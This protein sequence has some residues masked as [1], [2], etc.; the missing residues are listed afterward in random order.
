MAITPTVI[1]KNGSIVLI[2]TPTSQVDLPHKLMK[3]KAYVSR[4][5]PA[6]MIYPNTNKTL[7]ELRHP[8]MSLNDIKRGMDNRIAFTREYLCKPLS[9]GDELFPYE[10]IQKA[11]DYQD[12][13]I[14]KPRPGCKYFIG[15]D[16]AL[17]GKAGADYSAYVVY[18]KNRDGVLKIVRIE[19]YKGLSSLAQKQRIKE[20]NS[21]F[22]PVLMLGDEGTF[23]KALIEDL[24]AEHLPIKGFNFQGKRIELLE[25]FRGAFDVNFKDDNPLPFNERKFLICKNRKSVITQTLTEKLVSELLSFAIVFKVPKGKGDMTGRVVYEA[26]KSHSDI[27]MAS[28]LGYFIARNVRKVSYVVKSSSG[29]S[30]LISKTG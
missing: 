19:H 20:L 22:R 14:N 24:R 3:N 7:W 30:S 1:S 16:F 9:R 27:V 13:F 10:I 4:V 2:G 21:I 6:T 18:E 29:Y 12:A 11:F 28:A 8:N 17:S 5:Y 25:T 15:M 23:G 26:Q